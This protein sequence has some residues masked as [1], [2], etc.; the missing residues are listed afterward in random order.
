MWLVGWYAIHYA[1]FYDTA[2]RHHWLLHVEHA[3]L[4]SMGLVFW[5][6]V[7]C[8]RPNRL[9]ALASAGYLAAAFA[10]SAFLGLALT[11]ATRPV[12]DFY[13]EAPRIWGSPPSRT[14]TT[15]ASS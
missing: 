3:L 10:G 5:W 9:S 2:L 11:F 4:I 15:R 1:G 13:V 6:P 14:R 12:Y 7:V 8:G